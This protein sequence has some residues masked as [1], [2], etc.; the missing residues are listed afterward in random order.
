MQ[1]ICYSLVMI[2]IQI[3]DA[4]LKAD[5]EHVTT[6]PKT[7]LKTHNAMYDHLKY[8]QLSNMVTLYHTTD[9]TGA[10]NFYLFPFF[11]C[12]FNHMQRKAQNSK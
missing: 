2:Q 8:Y 5:M 10:F 3:N 1:L 9:N 7:L 4:F 11:I 12:V 6:L